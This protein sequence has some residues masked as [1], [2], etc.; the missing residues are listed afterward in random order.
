MA[1]VERTLSRGKRDRDLESAQ[2][3]S[4]RRKNSMSTLSRRLTGLFEENAQLRIDYLRL[5]QTW[6]KEI[7]N[8]EILVLLTMKSI[9]NLYLR[10]WSSVRR[11]NGPIRLK[12]KRSVLVEN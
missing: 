3:L 7:G 11:L 8:K 12:E 1:H 4:E 6:T 10:D 5:K 2:T 9:E